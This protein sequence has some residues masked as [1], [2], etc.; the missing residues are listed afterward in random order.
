MRLRSNCLISCVF[1][2][3]DPPLSLFAAVLRGRKAPGSRSAS[4]KRET[5]GERASRATQRLLL[6]GRARSLGT[7]VVTY[8]DMKKAQIS[9]G[10]ATSF[11]KVPFMRN[12]SPWRQGLS[13]CLLRSINRERA[14]C[15]K[16]WSVRGDAVSLYR[17]EHLQ[18]SGPN[19]Q[20][21]AGGG[22]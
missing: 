22:I 4:L 17:R 20:E 10:A 15:I 13:H 14:M 3:P 2:F 12:H 5:W 16:R 7:R 9:T 18:N 8:V 1:S 19:C 6:L 11:L 21:G